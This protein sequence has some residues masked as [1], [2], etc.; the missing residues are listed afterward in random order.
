MKT[1]LEWNRVT[2]PGVR[3]LRAV[4]L[5]APKLQRAVARLVAKCGSIFEYFAMRNLRR[6]TE[7]PARIT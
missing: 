3:L 5:R 4:R 7:R 6:A 1:S 2:N